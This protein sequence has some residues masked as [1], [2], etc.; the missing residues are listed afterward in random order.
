MSMKEQPAASGRPKVSEG[1][2]EL[3][4]AIGLLAF[5]IV[6]FVFINP[7]G[8][9]IYPGAGGMT[10]RT[11]PFFYSGA[12][13]CLALL[14]IVQSLLQIRRERGVEPAV[15]DPAAAAEA[16]VVAFRR[17][18]TLGLLLGYAMLLRVFGFAIMTP[19]FLFGLFQLYG[20]GKPAGDAG[21]SL[22]GGLAL[23]VLFVAILK[24]NL[25]GTFFDPVTPFLLK[26]TSL[27]GL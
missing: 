11:L 19:L 24:L 13:T 9:G 17:I 21:I 10:W 15:L 16:R 2:K 26:I 7:N 20:R 1:V 4:T 25:K 22:I 8:S 12:L 27:V 5:A 3:L 6:G 18:V 23:W 14:Y